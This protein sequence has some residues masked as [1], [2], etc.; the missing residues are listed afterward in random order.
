MRGLW[1]EDQRLRLR[2]DIP[3]PEAPVGEALVRVTLAGICN[4]DLELARGYYPFTGVPGHEFVGVVEAGPDGW[5]GKRVAGEINAACGACAGC[6]AGRRTHCENRTV[7]GIVKRDG[8]F[9]ERLAL[10]VANLHAVPERVTDEV[11]VFTEPLAAALQIQEQIDVPSSASVVVIG[12][13][14]LGQL[15]ARTLALTGCEL[16]VLGRH[17]A[18]RERLEKRGIRT[19]SPDDLPL[20]RADIVVECT[21]NAEGFGLARRAVRPR[22]TIVLKSTY[23]GEA[24]VDFS[25]VVVDEVRLVGSRCGPFEKA[26]P[27]LTGGRVEVTDLVDACY[28]LAQGLAA[29]EHAAR[30]GVLKVLLRP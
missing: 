21:G 27:L 9:A 19:G 30:P 11:A 16:L 1:L 2:D 8:T 15:V 17:A 14:K 4:T 13:G 10:P 26:L 6:A 12:D 7:L 23:R 24:S 20:H 5:V 25:S 18:K 22:G 29:F 28:P 3:L